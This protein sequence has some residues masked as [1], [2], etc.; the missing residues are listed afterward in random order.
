MNEHDER[1]LESPELQVR[2]VWRGDRW[3][4]E[5]WLPAGS[6]WQCALGSVEGTP[7]EDWPASPPLQSLEISN[8]ADGDPTALLVGMAGHSHWSASVQLETAARSVRFDVACRVPEASGGQLG[9]SYRAGRSGLVVEPE[10][11]ARFAP[12]RLERDGELIRLTLAAA[13]DTAAQ[14]IRWG[15]RVRAID[16]R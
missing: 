4:H 12:T 9:S 2:F 5:I 6:D 11:D 16:P 3:A 7:E 10:S 13:T 1:R 15:Y 8:G 14:T